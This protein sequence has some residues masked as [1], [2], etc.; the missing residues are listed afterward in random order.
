[1][2]AA[3]QRPPLSRERVLECAVA[4]AD[5]SGIGALTIRTLAQSMGTKPMSL[6]YYVANKDEILDGIVDMVFSEID[7]PAPGGDWRGEMQRRAH[8]VRSALRRHPWAVG[9]LESRS[10]PGPATLRHHEATLATLREAGFTVHLTA[11][12][13]ALLDSYIYGF[14]LQEAALPFEGRDTAAGITNPIMERFATGEY[15]RMVEIAVEHVLKPGYDFGDEFT[16]G[17]N[18]I[19]DGLERLKSGTD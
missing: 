7:P 19:L 15:P 14:A 16:F 17:L 13:Y 18:L 12:A 4:L 5:Q 1:M 6:Y 11:H 10:A 8:G 3:P 2:T 9:L